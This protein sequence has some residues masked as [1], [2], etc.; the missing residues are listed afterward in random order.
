MQRNVEWILWSPSTETALVVIPEEVEL[1]I[2]K[3]RRAVNWD[4]VPK[5]HIIAYAAPITKAMVPFNE[6]QYYVF[7]PLPS[8]A[9]FPDWLK[10]ELG[11][12]SG[13]LYVDMAEWASV[14]TYIGHQ[15]ST[16]NG[17]T[18]A[19][20]SRVSFGGMDLVPFADN[21][22]SFLLEWLGLRRKAQDVLHTPVGYICI[23]RTVG[24][25]HPFFACGLAALAVVSTH[26]G[27]G[28]KKEDEEETGMSNGYDE[29]E[30]ENEE[31][32]DDE[33]LDDVDSDGFEDPERSEESDNSDDAD[34]VD[35]AGEPHDS[36]HS[37]EEGEGGS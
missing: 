25:D 8:V 30:E 1:I 3:L 34:D 14:S 2:P 32:S 36:F 4:Q 33:Y 19:E 10:V 6:L 9:S 13:R 5:I 18:K 11:I 27:S 22:A 15:P 35:D 26:G 37:A 31:L 21:P 24:K 28:V 16:T 17:A 20:P 29:G 12:L 7:P 23:G